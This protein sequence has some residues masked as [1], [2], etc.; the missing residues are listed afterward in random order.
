MRKNK[1]LLIT[2]LGG[3]LGIHYFYKGKYKKGVL[4]LFTFGLLCIGWWYDIYKCFQKNEEK[5]NIIA[6]KDIGINSKKPFIEK[7]NVKPTQHFS[8]SL[9]DT[10]KYDCHSLI[11]TLLY[12]KEIDVEDLYNG[13]SDK[14]KK[15]YDGKIYEVN[16]Y[17]SLPCTI[18]WDEDKYIVKYDEHSNNYFFGIVPKD[19]N[20]KINNI[21]NNENVEVTSGD[22]RICGGYYQKFNIDTNK[23]EHGYDDVEITIHLNYRKK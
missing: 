18:A 15:Y 22:M 14:E 4:Y 16:K 17:N 21:I 3:W 7:N 5:S 23:F 20:E 11:S 12:F 6:K 13:M 2:I 19:Y 9:I 10:N 1:E 8:C